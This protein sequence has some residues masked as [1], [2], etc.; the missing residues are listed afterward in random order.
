MRS[1]KDR[2]GN[3]CPAGGTTAADYGGVRLSCILAMFSKSAC[4]VSCPRW[5]PIVRGAKAYQKCSRCGQR[6][7]GFVFARAG[8]VAEPAAQ[9][10]TSEAIP[11]LVLP[12]PAV[13]EPLPQGHHPRIFFG[14]VNPTDADSSFG[15]GCEEVVN[16]TDAVVPGTQIPITAFDPAQTMVCLPV[17]PRGAIVHAIWELINLATE[18]HNFHIH[19]TKLSSRIPGVAGSYVGCFELVILRAGTPQCCGGQRHAEWLPHH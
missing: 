17:G 5:I 7:N 15:V 6:E 14:L 10:M 8:P 18:T 3:S 1:A 9:P 19:Q 2:T 11:S 4:S 16:E 12:E 13:C